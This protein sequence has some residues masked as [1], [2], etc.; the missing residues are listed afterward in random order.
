MPSVVGVPLMQP[1]ITNF[2]VFSQKLTLVAWVCMVQ[3]MKIPITWSF[4][5]NQCVLK[6]KNT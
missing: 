2:V 5:Q 3:P 1:K 4:P 6:P